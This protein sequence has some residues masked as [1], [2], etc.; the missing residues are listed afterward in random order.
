MKKMLLKGGGRHEQMHVYFVD[1]STM[2][3]CE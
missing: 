2:K 1:E 3:F